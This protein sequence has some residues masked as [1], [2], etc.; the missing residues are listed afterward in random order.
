MCD[1]IVE[2]PIVDVLSAAELALTFKKARLVIIP[3]CIASRLYIP[4]TTSNVSRC[5]ADFGPLIYFVPMLTK[6]ISTS[7]RFSMLH[8]ADAGRGAG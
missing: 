3:A 5:A 4:S 7:E 1:A 8:R 2:H 6:E